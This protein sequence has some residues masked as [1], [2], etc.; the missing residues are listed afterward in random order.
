MFKSAVIDMNGMI[1]VLMIW[2]PNVIGHC[3]NELCN[4]RHEIGDK[5]EDLFGALG[6]FD[7]PCICQQELKIS[8]FDFPPYTYKSR[9]DRVEGLIPGKEDQLTEYIATYLTVCTMYH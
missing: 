2:L 6:A 3:E 5:L 7:E 1:W 9:N 8:Y 4:G